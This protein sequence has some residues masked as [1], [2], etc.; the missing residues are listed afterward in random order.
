MSDQSPQDR[1]ALGLRSA[2]RM[3]CRAA[4]REALALPTSVEWSVSTKQ[5][6]G[7]C[8]SCTA[9]IHAGRH[10][11]GWLADSSRPEL[12]DALVAGASDVLESIHSKVVERA[13]A[14]PLG[15]WMDAARVAMPEVT[16][17][18]A[19]ASSDCADAVVI[20]RAR[21]AN[22]LMS[23]PPAPDASVWSQ[24]R[25]SILDSV[26]QDGG[27]AA[28][29]D[30]GDTALV[31][32]RR[33]GWKALLAGAAASVAIG[34]LAVSSGTGIFTNSTIPGGGIS[35]SGDDQGGQTQFVIVD[36]G[37]APDVDFAVSRYGLR[38]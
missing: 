9:R 12:P 36:L 28:S 8:R 37:R 13:E 14:G 32:E 4:L 25:R 19:M 5:H 3:P 24:V 30:L 2:L 18:G 33:V 11:S 1:A 27:D 23:E 10:L 29:A 6:V 15:A 16:V 35:A 31:L 22:R 21:L 26:A 34:L 17:P 38:H 20:D 7:H